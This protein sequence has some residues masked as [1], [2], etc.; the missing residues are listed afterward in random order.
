MLTN[1]QKPVDLTFLL[2]FIPVAYA[3]Y[4]F[5]EFGHW[6]V[7]EIL[8]NRMVF[9]LNFVW[10]SD[11]HFIQSSHELYSSIGGPAFSI[12]QALL[13]LIVIEKFRALYAYPFAFFPMYSRFF[14]DL[15][16]GFGK[17]DEAKISTLMGIWTYL[18]AIIVLAVLLSIV[19]RCSY[20]LGLSIKNNG[21]VLVASTI[22]QLLV[23]GTYTFSKI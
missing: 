19:L 5:H 2:L 8:G 1:L 4:L 21:Y 10:P 17:Q 6:I 14:S 20:K 11:G 9:S 12:L 15:L 3:S 7:G 13:A 22:C 16:G 18:A 23:I